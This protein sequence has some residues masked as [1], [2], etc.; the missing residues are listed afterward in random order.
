MVFKKKIYP[1]AGRVLTQTN[2]QKQVRSKKGGAGTPP[3]LK[4]IRPFS[5]LYI[6]RVLNKVSLCHNL[7]SRLISIHSSL[8]ASACGI[9]Y[10][11]SC[12]R[13]GLQCGDPEGRTNT[14]LV[15]NCKY[16]Q[17]IKCTVLCRVE[18][19]QQASSAFLEQYVNGYK[20][21]S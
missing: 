3:T 9:T 12:Q 15:F 7:G 10:Q 4:R 2:I 14:N 18:V 11:I 1:E 5:V 8:Q 17:L 20:R 13:W 16:R 19:R 6:N 21:C